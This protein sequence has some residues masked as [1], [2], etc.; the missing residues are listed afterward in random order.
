MV[1]MAAII[2][3]MGLPKFILK[4]MIARRQKKFLSEMAD[5][6][7]CHDASFTRGDAGVRIH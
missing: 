2:G 3:F 5:A 1:I 7:G 4:R 6:L